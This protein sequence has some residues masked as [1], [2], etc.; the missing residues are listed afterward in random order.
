MS[1]W[2]ILPASG[3]LR[4]LA[5]DVS[6]STMWYSPDRRYI[7]AYFTENDGWA[8]FNPSD[9]GALQF[10]QTAEAAIVAWKM[11]HEQQT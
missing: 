2:I 8:V 3:N 5:R 7:C 4:G 9:L 6:L 10:H 1:D 11:R